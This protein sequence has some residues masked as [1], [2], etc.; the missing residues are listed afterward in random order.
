[1][2][3]PFLFL[4]AYFMMVLEGLNGRLPNQDLLNSFNIIS[5][6]TGGTK[7]ILYDS[8]Q[9]G[10]ELPLPAWLS[11]IVGSDSWRDYMVQARNILKH[12]SYQAFGRASGI[13]GLFHR[14]V[15]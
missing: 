10:M 6:N 4:N 3:M 14:Q 9:D 2:S 1:M 13:H 5:S 8:L 15:L 12:V 11:D 7:V